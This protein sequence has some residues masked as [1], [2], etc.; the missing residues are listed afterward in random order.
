MQN[1]QGSSSA[2]LNLEI[3]LYWFYTLDDYVSAC[4]R[5]INDYADVAQLARASPC[6]GEGCEFESRHPLFLLCET[7]ESYI[8]SLIQP[9]WVR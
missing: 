4:A 1:T 8:R 3:N 9:Y 7:N 5:L 6:H 2:I